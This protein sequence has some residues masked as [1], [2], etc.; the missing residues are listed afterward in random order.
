MEALP[1]NTRL[2]GT[3]DAGDRRSIGGWQYM[4][5]IRWGSH[6]G[7]RQLH[8]GDVQYKIEKDHRSLSLHELSTVTWR[9]RR[10]CIE[11]SIMYSQGFRRSFAQL[12][13]A[14]EVHC[15]SGISQ[16]PDISIS[17]STPISRSSTS[18]KYV[19]TEVSTCRR[20]CLE[21]AIA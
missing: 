7:S 11:D 17:I 14:Y 18:V 4:V 15:E 13:Q 21:H 20:R 5:R 6:Q 10:D 9:R 16:Y 2:Q 8:T 19:W 1:N 3:A 12:R